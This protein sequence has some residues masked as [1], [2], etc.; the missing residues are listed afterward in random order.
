MQWGERIWNQNS[1]YENTDFE[2]LSENWFL[3]NAYI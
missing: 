1:V 2:I 3:E